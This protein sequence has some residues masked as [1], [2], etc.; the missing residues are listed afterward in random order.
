M[1]TEN[2]I[3]PDA[4]Q[5]EQDRL[6]QLDIADFLKFKKDFVEGNCPACDS[7]N[8]HYVFTKYELKHDKC[9]ECGTI[10]IN[11]RPTS[12]SLRAYYSCSRNYQY[13]ANHIFPQSENSRVENIFKPRLQRLIDNV[14][15]FLPNRK[16]KKPSLLEVGPGFGTFLELAN[17]SGCFNEVAAIE[18]TPSLADSIEKRGIGVYR[19]FFEDYKSHDKYDVICAFEVIEHIL[20]PLS[21]VEKSREILD[22]DGLLYLSCPNANSVEISLLGERSCAVDIEHVNLFTAEGLK[23]LFE[24]RGF[25]LL[26]YHTPG[27]IDVDLIRKSLTKEDP[28][29]LHL[30]FQGKDSRLD[31]LQNFISSSNMSSHMCLTFRKV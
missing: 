18:P 4:L 21:F 6:F 16:G 27:L 12:E 8:R 10:F 26:H 13:W 19:S 11:P 29:F 31:L 20:E 23:K 9:G 24:N 14:N 7:K 25:E 28:E 5:K 17:N 1:I 30:M 22:K 15:R 3:R 2:D